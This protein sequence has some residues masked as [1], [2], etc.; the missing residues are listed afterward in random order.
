M[1]SKSSSRQPQPD[2]QAGPIYKSAPFFCFCCMLPNTVYLRQDKF[3]SQI[4][5]WH[6]PNEFILF[7]F[8]LVCFKPPEH[9]KQLQGSPGFVSPPQAVDLPPL[10]NSVTPNE[11]CHAPVYT[12]S[13]NTA[14]CTTSLWLQQQKASLFFGKRTDHLLHCKHAQLLKR[15]L[16]GSADSFHSGLCSF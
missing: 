8:L 3:S 13:P 7:S 16:L 10:I 1:P 2:S 5:I 15:Q 14:C 12:E 6:S 9:D 4:C 11:H